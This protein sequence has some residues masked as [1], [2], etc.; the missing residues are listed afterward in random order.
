MLVSHFATGQKVK[1]KILLILKH[2]NHFN[3]FYKGVHCVF[4]YT[5]KKPQFN[6]EVSIPCN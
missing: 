5:W 6:S 3:R 4:I 1:V 2:L